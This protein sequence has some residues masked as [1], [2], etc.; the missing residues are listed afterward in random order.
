MPESL[1]LRDKT[2]QSHEIKLTGNYTYKS[3]IFYKKNSLEEQGMTVLLSLSWQMI[4]T[5]KTSLSVY[6]YLPYRM[7]TI[8]SKEKPLFFFHFLPFLSLRNCMVAFSEYNA[9]TLDRRGNL[10]SMLI[11]RRRLRATDGKSPE[12]HGIR[13]HPLQLTGA[14]GVRTHL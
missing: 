5:K 2:G 6:H 4:L 7:K 11:E 12:L 9:Q 8:Q 1:K 3:S 13:F 10:L 14:G